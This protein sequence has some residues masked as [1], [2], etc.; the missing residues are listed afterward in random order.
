MVL[1]LNLPGCGKA[2]ARRLIR[3]RY[4]SNAHRGN[5][6]LYDSL[7]GIAQTGAAQAYKAVVLWCG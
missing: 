5:T 3:S 6:G 4:L 2:D 7:S 1:L